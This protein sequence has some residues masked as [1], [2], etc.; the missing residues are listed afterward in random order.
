MV[1]LNVLFGKLVICTYMEGDKL[2]QRDLYD[3]NILVM[4]EVATAVKLSVYVVVSQS[5]KE[6]FGQQNNSA[7]NM[8]NWE[9]AMINSNTLVGWHN[10]FFGG[11]GP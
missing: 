11:T 3:I 1:K 7:M 4:E 8:G 6:K 10:S 2:A 5:G 9:K